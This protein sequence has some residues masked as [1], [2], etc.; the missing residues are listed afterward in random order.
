MAEARDRAG[1][2][3]KLTWPG[4]W[5]QERV[6]WSFLFFFF[7]FFLLSTSSHL[8]WLTFILAG[9]HF[10]GKGGKTNLARNMQSMW[11]YLK[12]L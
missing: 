1:G 7:L 8:F 4:A 6:N 5:V 3:H 2:H 11:K 12:I 10:Y 9:S